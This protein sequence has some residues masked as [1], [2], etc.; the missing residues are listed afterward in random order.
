MPPHAAASHPQRWRILSVL[1]VS[2]LM[3]IMDN[4]IMNVAVRTIADPTV[5]LGATQSELEWIINSYTLIFAG[6]LFTCGVM[7]DRHGRKRL[8]MAGIA[9][10]GAASLVA[11]FAATPL[12]L[13]LMRAAMGIGG[14]AVMPT[15][16]AIIGTVFSAQDRPK[17]IGVWSGA[18]GMG[19]ALGPAL[20]GFLLHNFHWSSIFW[21]NVP[22]AVVALVACALVV[23]ESRDP[24]PGR[25]D[26]LGVGLS[27]VGLV[28]LCFGLIRGGDVGLGDPLAAASIAGAV[29]V[30]FLF[31]VHESR[32]ESPAVDVRLFRDGRFSASVTTVGLVFF[33]L[34][35]VS[36]TSAFYVQSVLGLD[37]FAAGLTMMPL[38]LCLMVSGPASGMLTRRFGNRTVMASG[39]AVMTL[40]MLMVVIY[41]VNSPVLLPTLNGALIGLAMGA[42]MP[43]ATSAV[44]S[45]VPHEKMGAGAAISSTMRQVGAAMGVAVIGSA[46]AAA[47][48]A[49][50]APALD[51]L[52]PALRAAAAGSVQAS[53]SVAEA[54]HDAALALAAK[55]A[56]VHAMHIGATIAAAVALVGLFVVLRW[57][58]ARVRP[59]TAA[60][61]ATAE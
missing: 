1:I 55:A 15:T 12:Q 4:T 56:Y 24:H 42:I 10:F 60:A 32:T 47:Y 8:L 19:L 7:A 23:P 39:L 17:A 26:P 13:I 30:L 50:I 54:T 25:H 46:L 48:R 3:M 2:L 18:V 16:L 43:P 31:V 53:L 44:M 11:T 14:A 40:A 36:F 38:A 9:A 20:G 57:V 41:R 51:G 33:T 27:I 58:P 45:S 21:V 37:P 49:S 59:A 22:V 61:A 34:M 5:G 28:G 29:A 6:L 35:G 52:A